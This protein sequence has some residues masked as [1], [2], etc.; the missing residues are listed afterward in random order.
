MAINYKELQILTSYD[1]PSSKATA[2]RVMFFVKSLNKLFNKTTV[3][4]RGKDIS[5]LNNDKVQKI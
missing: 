4:S 5:Y 1:C 3:I 2:N